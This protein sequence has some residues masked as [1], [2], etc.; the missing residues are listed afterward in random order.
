MVVI[1]TPEN[2]EIAK[3]VHG[4]LRKVFFKCWNEFKRSAN[5]T[6][7]LGAEYTDEWSKL[8]KIRFLERGK[9]PDKTMNWPYQTMNM[10]WRFI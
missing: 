6:S 7:G 8:K 1:G 3:Y 5:D 2:I 10:N 4:Y 9:N